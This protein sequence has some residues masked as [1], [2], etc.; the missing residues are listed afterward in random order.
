MTTTL[1]P[2]HTAQRRDTRTFRR[3]A[4]A[5]LLPFGPLCV[6]IL[7]GILPYYTD[8]TSQEMLDHTAADL[9]RMDAVVWLGLLAALTLVPSALAAARLAQRRAPLLSLIGVTLL[10]AGYLA[11]PLVANDILLRAAADLDRPVGVQLLDSTNAYGAV[12]VAG[13]L[14]V[15]GHILGLILL[16]VALWRAGAIP[17]WAA[18]ALIVS[19]PL[20]AVFAVVVP[21]HALDAAAWGLTALGLLVA[22]IRVLRTT[23]N[24]WDLGPTA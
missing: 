23:D 3:V 11:L 13:L 6:A 16:G 14:F 10:V 17:A 15:A 9:G 1:A 22:A 18:I 2:P 7:R 8:D 4:A 19:Q 24:D 5:V 20:H 12:A 21:N